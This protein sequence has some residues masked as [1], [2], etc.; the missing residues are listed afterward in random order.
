M[1]LGKG[2]VGGC[3]GVVIGDEEFRAVPVEL[4]G[5]GGRIVDVAETKGRVPMIVVTTDDDRMMGGGIW[6]IEVVL[7]TSLLPPF[8]DVMVLTKGI[9]TRIV[10][11]IGAVGVLGCRVETFEGK[12]E[13]VDVFV[14]M[15][16]VGVMIFV[17]LTELLGN[18]REGVMLFSDII[19]MFKE[20]VGLI[21]ML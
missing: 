16:V 1:L 20:V 17:I 2:S 21:N 11:T 8:G 15:T 5:E 12:V 14:K 19:G 7:I 9:V 4:E 18:P 3:E 6:I 10:D 13:M